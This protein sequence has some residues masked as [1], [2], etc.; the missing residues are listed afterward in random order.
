M[1][2][3][4]FDKK[5]GTI[6]DFQDDPGAGWEKLA[7][8]WPEDMPEPSVGMLKDEDECAATLSHDGMEK[9]ARYPIN[10]PE[11]ALASSMYFL[12]YGVDQIEKE[13]H[14]PIAESLKN[15][16]IAHG[17]ELPRDFVDFCKYA[18]EEEDDEVYADDTLPVTTPNQCAQSIV[19]FNKYASRWKSDDRMVVGR[20]LAH[21]AEHHGLE[22]VKVPYSGESLV[23]SA[24]N[25]LQKREEVMEVLT[26]H[27]EHDKYLTKIAFMQS[28]L[29]EVYGYE[30]LVEL[31]ADLEEIDKEAG[32]DV[33]WNDYYPDPASTFIDEYET[34]PLEALLPK[35]AA[36]NW[37]NVDWEGMKNEIDEDLVEKIASDP[38]TIV[39]TLP[40]PYQDILKEYT[41]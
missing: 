27:P 20:K 28:R 1:N 40:T 7:S 25:A 32:M 11:D 12:R 3:W 9:V 31:A 26:D 8:F 23:K 16:R 35:Q 15:A 22:G 4:K 37:D 21:A 13:A 14:I 5:P 39:P 24:S 33:G 6:I 2:T 30:D 29:D 38:D 41:R 17:V 36:T 10:T 34:D 18:S 19:V